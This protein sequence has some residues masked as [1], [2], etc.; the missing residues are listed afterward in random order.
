MRYCFSEFEFDDDPLELR[1]GDRVLDLQP[2]VLGVL[3]LLVRSAGAVVTKDELLAAVWPDV[4]VTE[5]SLTRCVSII[6]RELGDEVVKTLRGRGYRMGVPVRQVDPAQPEVAGRDR[7]SRGLRWGAVL[8]A[9]VLVVLALAWLGRPF[10]TLPIATTP[11]APAHAATDVAVVPVEVVG[12]QDPG[13]LGRRIALEVIDRLTTADELRVVS[14]QAAFDEAASGAGPSELG[15]RLEV[16]TLVLG[17]IRPRTGMLRVSVEVVEAET[18]F[19]HWSRSFDRPMSER[20][21]LPA[22][23]AGHVA[24]VLG[25]SIE[26]AVGYV[27][28]AE[29]ESARLYFEGREAV[30]REKRDHLLQAVAL[31]ERAIELDP[32]QARAYVALASAY[33][34]LWGEDGPGSPW[35]D[36]GEAAARIA[37]ELV[38]DHPEALAVLASLRRDRKDWS[39][40]LAGYAEA[41][42]AGPSTR[43][44]TGM[45]RLLCM[46]GRPEEAEPHARAAIDLE[47]TSADAHF[48]MARVDY[49]LGRPEAAVAHLELAASLEPGLK[50]LPTLLARAYQAAGREDAAREA[51]LLVSARWF[52]PVL[53]AT[54]RLLGTDRSLRLVMWL[55]ELRRGTRCPANG[56]GRA[57][58]WA[59]LGETERM[60]ECMEKTARKH[61]WYLASEP[62]F[63]PHRDDPRFRALLAREGV[64]PV[65]DA[66]RPMAVGIRSD[67]VQIRN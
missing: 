60:Y 47:P 24:R 42:R 52:R 63:D 56:M 50:D 12:M 22:E 32:R 34:R 25:A 13:D 27:N 46:I 29:I 18:G 9:P 19:P 33:E 15:R 41:I 59:R 14:A 64:G 23:I 37:L 53:R 54:D 2:K 66:A 51:F 38:P 35:L 43:A 17:T 48:T 7:R 44:L 10:A 58:V 6:R 61:P 20:E 5:A 30:I 16:G 40:A 65:R 45:A 1:R 39:G 26:G 21:A 3:L 8:G 31:F 36:R 11:G 55:D 62:G 49:Y 57:L 4:A 67:P 28:D